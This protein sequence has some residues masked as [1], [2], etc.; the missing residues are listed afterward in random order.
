MFKADV[1]GEF[2][3]I[4]RKVSRDVAKRDRV[5]QFTT[6]LRRL[7]VLRHMKDEQLGKLA[8]F[9]R[10]ESMERGEYLF[11]ENDRSM[12]FYVVKSGRLEVRKDTPFGPQL[13]ASIGNDN[14]L[15]EMNFIDRAQR[16]TDAVATEPSTCYTFSFS[17]LD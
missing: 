4:S 14:I 2:K 13:L 15:G 17:A 12:D 10:A 9:V 6:D 11:R 3:A 8:K 7:D 5:A 16:S 1:R